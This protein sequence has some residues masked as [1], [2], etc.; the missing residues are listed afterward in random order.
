L[1]SMQRLPAYYVNRSTG[2]GRFLQFTSTS[3]NFLHGAKLSQNLFT[4]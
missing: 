1:A 2:Y 3:F 4:P